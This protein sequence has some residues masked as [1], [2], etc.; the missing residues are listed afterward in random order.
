MIFSASELLPLAE[1]TGYKAEILL[2]NDPVL[3]ARIQNQPLLQWKAHHV[4]K[5]KGLL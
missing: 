1:R 3:Q 5:H 2:T 4:R